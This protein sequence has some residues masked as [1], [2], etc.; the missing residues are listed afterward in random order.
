MCHDWLLAR[1]REGLGGGGIPGLRMVASHFCHPL[2]PEH[3][4]ARH[5]HRLRDPV[6]ES[7]KGCGMCSKGLAK[8]TGDL[9]RMRSVRLA[10]AEKKK[11]ICMTRISTF[12]GAGGHTA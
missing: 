12:R 9:T 5:E 7:F 10:L 3:P 2:S 4:A 1:V 6:L 11:K 8:A